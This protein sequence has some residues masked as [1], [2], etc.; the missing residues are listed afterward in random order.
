M[1]CAVAD[2]KC[3]KADYSSA[4]ARCR[5]VEQLIRKDAQWAWAK[6]EVNNKD[7]RAKM[8]AVE[9]ATDTA[10]FAALM[11]VDMGKWKKQ[12]NEAGLSDADQE[13]QLKKILQEVQPKVKMLEMS[14]KAMFDTHTRRQETERA[15]HAK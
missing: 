4:T 1:A 6:H 8:Q 3:L 12:A 14:V 13:V 11:Q 2:I 9:E 5:T 15:Q 7:M 10:E